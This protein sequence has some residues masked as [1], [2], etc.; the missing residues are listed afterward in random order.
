MLID[1][2]RNKIIAWI[3]KYIY[4]P[5]FLRRFCQLPQSPLEKAY[6]LEQMRALDNGFKLNCIPLPYDAVSINTI[7][8]LEKAEV[9]SYELYQM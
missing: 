3:K 4:T 2:L 1:W 5:D 9:D 7:E 8:D 6:S